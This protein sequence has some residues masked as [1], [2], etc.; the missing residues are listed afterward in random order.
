MELQWHCG[1]LDALA[2]SALP[3][4]PLPP[5]PPPSPLL[6]PLRR[7]SVR[8]A[9]FGA[10]GDGEGER[11]AAAELWGDAAE[12]GGTAAGCSLR[13]VEG[14]AVGEVDPTMI[15]RNLPVGEVDSSFFRIGG[16]GRLREIMVGALATAR[17]TA[18][19]DMPSNWTT[20]G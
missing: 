17:V 5:P 14:D 4:S 10:G 9:W 19:L 12:G 8:R 3:P 13:V 2:P 11:A 18:G 7:A 6:R 1:E 15:S 20:R 16:D